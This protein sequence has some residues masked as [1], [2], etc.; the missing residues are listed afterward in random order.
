MG[1][2][3]ARVAVAQAV[4]RDV[5]DVVDLPG[6]AGRDLG[7]P[8]DH[9]DDLGEVGVGAHDPGLLGAL[10]QRLAGGEQRRAAALEQRRVAVDV[11]EQLVG[12]RLLG[13]Q[14]AD[15]AVQPADERL[16]RRQVVEVGG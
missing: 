7:D 13:G 2:S 16:P 15:E 10:Q 6:L 1:R 11:V 5:E 12:Q 3:G 4:E 14:V 9:L 8:A